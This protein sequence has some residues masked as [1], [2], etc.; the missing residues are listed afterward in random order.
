[1]VVALFVLAAALAVRL[2]PIASESFHFDAIAHQ[3]AAREGPVANAWDRPAAY[4]WRRFHPPLVSY[5]IETNNGIVG[6]GAFR[7]RLYSILFGAAACSLVA[8][9][10]LCFGWR[11]PRA[12]GKPAWT[13]GTRAGAL[14]AGLLLCFLP[15]HL[16]VSR[17]AN[18]DAVYSALSMGALLFLA[19]HVARPSRGALVAA[20]VAAALAFL[21]CEL[22][23]VLLPAI[24]LVFALDRRRRPEGATRWWAAAFVWALVTLAVLWP[25]GVFKLDILRTIRFRYLDSTEAERN[26]PWTAFYTTLWRQA[27]AYTVAV[28]L[29]VASLV[30][31][32]ARRARAGLP[33]ER[34]APFAVYCATVVLLSTRQRLVY[35][36]H[37]DDLFGPLSVLAGA[38]FVAAYSASRRAAVRVAWAAV[39]VVLVTGGV[40]A[41]L[42]DDPEVVGPQEHP[43]LLSI[44]EF[45]AEHPGART[46]YHYTTQMEYYAPGADV[47]GTVSRHWDADAIARAKTGGYDFVVSDASQ[48]GGDLVP[49]EKALERALAPQY[50]LERVIRHRR[51]GEPVAWIFARRR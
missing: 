6:E 18:W 16:Y 32:A 3:I 1:V 10:V 12:A 14:M 46:F 20:L 36:H 47:E 9:S 37:I 19:L 23:L 50:R 27:P 21:S 34:L 5:L 17:S 2:H 11:R 51:T 28:V 43:G 22:G 30:V 26:L 33:L 44:G 29:G 42:G 45:L 39:A 7:S 40:R 31:A 48:L 25:A 49:D 38:G 4:Q 13:A 24:A 41:G 15:V 35:I 8:L